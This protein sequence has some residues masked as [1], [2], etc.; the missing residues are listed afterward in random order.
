MGQT[1]ATMTHKTF[2]TSEKR[3]QYH[4]RRL[5]I[6]SGILSYYRRIEIAYRDKALEP[7]ESLQEV[8][9]YL[10]K[11]NK[12]L[13]IHGNGILIW[14]IYKIFGLNCI[15]EISVCNRDQFLAGM[16]VTRETEIHSSYKL[17]IFSPSQYICRLVL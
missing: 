3:N 10:N 13:I 11:L 9:Q 14:E 17:S 4:E 1:A 7:S 6:F 12:V 5:V 15:G 2:V 16:K 8:E